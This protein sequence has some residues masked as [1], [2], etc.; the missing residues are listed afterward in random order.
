VEYIL[1]ILV[2]VGIY[3]ILAVSLD[4]LAGCTGMLSIA[5]A[6]FFGVGAYTTAL[7][8][9]RFGVPFP[10]AVVGSVALSGLVAV[11]VALPALRTRGDYFVIGT[12]AL[13]VVAGG[14]MTNWVAVTGGP[15]GVSGIP[16]P[17]LLGWEVTSHVDF[18]VLVA[19]CLAAVVAVARRLARSAYGRVLNAIRE[20]EVWAQALGKDVF[21]FRMVVFVISA[22][23]AGLG[24]VLYASYISFIDPSSFT[25]MESIFIISIVIVGGAGSIWGSVLGALVLVV[26]PEVLRAVGLPPASAAHLRQILYGGLLVVLVMWRP[27]GFLGERV[28][29]TPEETQ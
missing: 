20:D 11:G 13:Q 25:V 12:F 26:V 17:T 15:V 7:L 22:A 10:V 28:F 14:V 29:E 6:A 18:V 24:G 16:R 5:Q 23:M 8:G 21:R 4:L 19:A 9:T 27:R 3:A 1:H 2:F